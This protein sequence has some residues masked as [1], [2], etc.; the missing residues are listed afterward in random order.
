[1]GE[2]ERNATRSDLIFVSIASYRDPELVPTV[3]DCLQKARHPERLRFGICWQHA[4]D[5]KLPAWFRGE[6]FRILDVDSRDSGGANWARAQVMGLWQGEQWY[7]QLDSHH[8]FAPGWDA[9]LLDEFR[10]ISSDRAI[11]TSYAPPYTPDDPEAA[12]DVPMSMRFRDF[13]PDGL[14]LFMPTPIPDGRRGKGPQPAR[15]ASAHLLFAPG[16]FVH[17]VPSDPEL[18]FNGDEAMLAVRAYTHGYD[19]FEPS[20]V[21]VWHQYERP[22]PKHWDD[23]R[24]DGATPAWHQR[25]ADSRAKMR[26]IFDELTVGPFGLGTARTLTEYEAYAGISFGYR[27]V[28]DYTRQNRTPPNPPADRDWPLRMSHHRVTIKVGAEQVSRNAL[29]DIDFW[30]VAVHDAEGRDIHQ[31][32][33]PA[34]ELGDLARRLDVQKTCSVTV[35]FDSQADPQTWTITPYRRTS[36]WLRAISG[37]VDNVE[38]SRLDARRPRRVPGVK[39]ESAGDRLVASLPGQPGRTR[40]LN[41]SGALLVEMADG[42]HSVREI[43]NYLKD[44]HRLDDDP[45]YQ[46]IDFYESA[47]SA[48]LVTIGEQK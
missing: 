19:L 18:Y 39:W 46:L 33:I 32:E 24:G 44:V 34:D 41:S 20:R 26:R 7:L 1:M 13:M 8:R 6:H 43:A 11:L 38:S 42:Q 28:Q 47:R 3:H 10:R 31:R 9:V 12:D 22:A 27:K 16:S 4:Q 36:G 29:V 21:I 40:E 23:H 2:S 45:V 48:G 37:A 14:P 17:D 30:H 15:F 35:D 5:E 25:D